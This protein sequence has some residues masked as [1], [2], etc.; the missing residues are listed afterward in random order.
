VPIKH[1]DRIYHCPVCQGTGAFELP[2]NVKKED[3]A[4]KVYLVN[5]L[6]KKGYGLRQIQRA[7]GYKSP[8][9]ISHILKNQKH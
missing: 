8:Q 6:H 9:S 3:A 1:P 7:L 4:I 5:L 2:K